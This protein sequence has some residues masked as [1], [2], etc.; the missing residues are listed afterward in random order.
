M[1]QCAPGR[2]LVR[3]AAA[4]PNTGRRLTAA[5]GGLPP[6]LQLGRVLGQPTQPVAVAAAAAAAA[7]AAPAALTA[8]QMAALAGQTATLHIT[9]S[10]PVMQ[11]VAALQG[12]PGEAG[13]L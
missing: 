12:N 4:G 2:V 3:F 10:R 11:V 9:D 8:G 6:G 5:G 7:G 13:R 1:P